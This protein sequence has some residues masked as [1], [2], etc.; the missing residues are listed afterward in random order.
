MNS[1][2]LIKLEWL[3]YRHNKAIWLSLLGFVI[4]LLIIMLAYAQM[5]VKMSS[6]PQGGLI[7]LKKNIS[8]PEIWEFTGYIGG[9]WIGFFIV[10]FLG[11]YLMAT[12]IAQKT[13]RQQI[14]SGLSRGQYLLSK[15]LFF[16][17]IA[18][19]LTIFYV[20]VVL[21]I[22]FTKSYD[23]VGEGI[24][25]TM[26]WMAL[27]FFVMTM[28]YI[29]LGGLFGLLFKKTIMAFLFYLF[30]GIF[31]EP[32]IRW[33]IHPNFAPESWNRFYPM[34][35]AEDLMP[36]PGQR[37]SQ[38]DELLQDGSLYL[39]ANQA[40]ITSIVYLIIIFTLMYGLMQRKNV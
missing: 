27:R 4:V 24:W 8:F 37:I 17:N 29:F 23:S 12:E 26:G 3:K 39:T 22:G 14:I 2:K 40:L 16:R 9:N 11:T 36:S 35:A 34:N 25:L 5:D 31:L 28:L 21:F 1:L 15:L 7:D 10:G 32:V 18:T 6:G 13:A 38:F 30:Y 19:I 20:V 33:Y